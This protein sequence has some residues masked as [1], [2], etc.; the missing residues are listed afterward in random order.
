MPRAE[1][2]HA[3]TALATGAVAVAVVVTVR[4]SVLRPTVVAA[5]E[6][7]RLPPPA[8]RQ[9]LPGVTPASMGEAWDSMLQF[10]S[11]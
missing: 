11:R 3:S 8:E 6:P 5:A 9:M 10:A 2:R 4:V 1:T 7:A